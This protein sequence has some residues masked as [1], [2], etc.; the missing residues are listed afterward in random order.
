[1]LDFICQNYLKI[2]GELLCPFLQVLDQALA[3]HHAPLLV[4]GAA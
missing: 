3:H 4:L 2:T 1:M